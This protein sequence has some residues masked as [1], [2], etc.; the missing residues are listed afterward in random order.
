M[1]SILV[2]GQEQRSLERF[3]RILS[4]EGWR[5]RVAQGRAQALQAAASERPDLVLAAAEVPGSEELAAAF[6]RDSGGPGVV[7]IL[8][9]GVPAGPALSGDDRLSQPFGDEE[10]VL[11]IRRL[12]LSAQPP[13]MPASQMAQTVR[14]TS[15]DIFGDV[16]AEVEGQLGG[17]TPFPPTPPGV[18]AAQAAQSAHQPPSTPPPSPSAPRAAGGRDDGELQR[19]LE[20]TLSGMLSDSRPARPSGAA[21]PSAAA[22]RGDADIDALLNR[23]LSELGA[24]PRTAQTAPPSQATPPP[25]AQTP[26]ASATP[27]SQPASTAQPSPAA[28]T[29]RAASTMPPAPPPA[30][31]AQAPQAVQPAQTPQSLEF[32]PASRTQQTS[33]ESSGSSAQRAPSASQ[34]PW[35]TPADQGSPAAPAVH[36]ASTQPPAY[37]APPPLPPLPVPSATGSPQPELGAGPAPVLGTRPPSFAPASPQ[38]SPPAAPSPQFAPASPAPGAPPHHAPGDPP[39]A[40]QAPPMPAAAPAGSAEGTGV[41]RRFTGDL[42]LSQLEELARTRRRTEPVSNPGPSGVQTQ[43]T[44][45]APRPTQTVQQARP[46]LP[47]D[48]AP[49]AWPPQSV[50]PGAPGAAADSP[51]ATQRIQMSPREPGEPAG[52]RFGQYTLLERIAMGGMA[53]VWKARMRG[54]EGFQKTVAIK[55]ILPYM[56]DN[57]DFVGMFI[58]EAKFAAQLSHPNIIHIYDLGKIGAD[59][60]IAMEYVEGK[61]LRSLLNSARQRGLPLPL[62]LALLIALR[63]ASALDY[64]HRKRDFEGREMGLVHRDVSPQNVLISYDGDVKLCDFGIAKAVSKVGQT[65]MGALKGK[66]QYMSPEQARGSVV[67]G[68]SDIFSLG[69]VLFEMLT[70]ERLF[71]GDSEMSVLEAVRQVRVRAPRQ[72]NPAVPADVDAL[73]MRAL[74]GRPEDRFQNAGELE[75]RL[76]AVLYELKPSPSHSDLA[77]YVRHVLDKPAPAGRPDRFQAAMPSAAALAAGPGGEASPFAQPPAGTASAVGAA[78]E[79]PA[80][81]LPSPPAP[82]PMPAAQVAT[83]SPA[84]PPPSSAATAALPSLSELVSGAPGTPYAQPPAGP[85]PAAGPSPYPPM[86]AAGSLGTAE[87]AAES[88]HQDVTPLAPLGDMPVEEGSRSGRLILLGAIALLVVVVLAYFFFGR[89][90]AAPPPVPPAQG[91]GAA[92]TSGRPNGQPA[93]TGTTGASPDAAAAGGAPKSGIVG[94]TGAAGAPAA[95]KIDVNGLVDQ[96]LQRRADALKKKFEEQQKQLQKELDKTKAA[97]PAGEAATAPAS[98]GGGMAAAGTSSTAAGAGAAAASRS[99]PASAPAAEARQA[100]EPAAAPPQAVPPPS[101]AAVPERAEAPSRSSAEPAPSPA[102]GAAAGEAGGTGRT[103]PPSLVSSIKPEYPPVARKLRVEGVVVVNVL[104]DEQG[105][106]EDVRLLEPIE[107]NVGINEAALQVA[108]AARFKPAVRDGARIKMWTRLRIPFKL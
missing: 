75:Q 51:M 48:V 41:R 102:P 22:R 14:L 1:A 20:R 37:G 71:D 63:L 66:L 98:T 91:A 27:T 52:E 103:V 90:A 65:E 35:M 36:A 83:S 40:P 87:V 54:V 82:S 7:M 72:V 32:L 38:F 5:V 12:L 46:A 25:A 9:E 50:R 101:P 74:A 70:G 2:V 28:P 57:S 104:V 92:G 11:K 34:A 15:Q 97:K 55:K 45:Q 68:R 31:S 89:R 8:A 107:Q 43:Q 13:P 108:R 58:D 3:H 24:K 19:K 16:L 39:P 21:G 62:G 81:G 84:P 42:D 106:V 56:T 30:G 88:S 26:S 80:P 4:A 47:A 96:E 99:G 77:A 18:A 76:E 93:G 17:R 10:L 73:V 23:T 29:A 85:V 67:D 59:F 49:P 61:D 44:P 78:F 6:R 33:P 86:T 69:T 105:H 53:E 95:G 79:A 64:A 94:T 100:A 60:Y